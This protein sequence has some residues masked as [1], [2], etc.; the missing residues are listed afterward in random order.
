MRSLGSIVLCALALAPSALGTSDSHGLAFASESG[1]CLLA[2]TH[3]PDP[4]ADPCPTSVSQSGTIS[5]YPLP[6]SATTSLPGAPLCPVVVILDSTG[7][8]PT[9]SLG[10]PYVRDIVLHVAVS[11]E[12]VA[13]AWYA[14]RHSEDL[15]EDETGPAY[16]CHG[17]DALAVPLDAVTLCN[18]VVVFTALHVQLARSAYTEDRFRLCQDESGYPVLTRVDA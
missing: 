11:A 2:S 13:N 3:I 9:P 15:C 1:E 5:T 4:F 18:E 12:P 16:A 10:V 7:S 14:Y 6:C 17:H 8:D